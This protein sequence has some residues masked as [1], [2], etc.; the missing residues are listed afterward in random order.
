VARGPSGGAGRGAERSTDSR[1]DTFIL[2]FISRLLNWDGRVGVGMKIKPS[3]YFTA[4]KITRINLCEIIPLFSPLFPKLSRPPLAGGRG[5]GVS[6]QGCC[7]VF[8]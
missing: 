5:R 2:S 1:E 3:A 4:V 8:F 7:T 6:R